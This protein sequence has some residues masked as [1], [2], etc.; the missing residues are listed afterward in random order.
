MTMYRPPR[1]VVIRLSDGTELIEHDPPGRFGPRIV[2]EGP[3]PAQAD[4]S[5]DR[6]ENDPPPL[7]S[8]S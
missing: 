8:V 7:D 2:N 6:F 1:R 3:P 5:I 4:P